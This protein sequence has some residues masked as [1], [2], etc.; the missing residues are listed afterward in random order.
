MMIEV[1]DITKARETLSNAQKALSRS[2]CGG[3]TETDC[4]RLQNMIDQVNSRPST[5]VPLWTE[6][7]T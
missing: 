3:Q 1:G 2:G 5:S 7:W 6:P 4:G